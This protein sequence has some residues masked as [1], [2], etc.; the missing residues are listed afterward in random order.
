M[1][2]RWKILSLECAHLFCRWE[3]KKNTYPTLY[4]TAKA[5]LSIPATSVPSERVF[6]LAGFIVR[7]R[8]ARLTSGNVNTLI[9]L[10]KN[11]GNI[12]KDFNYSCEKVEDCNDPNDPDDP[13]GID[14]E[15]HY[16]LID[17]YD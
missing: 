15:N 11:F 16:D 3:S 1:P 5:L 14:T 7:K 9:F 13:Q 17:L 10:N 12:P 2:S 8:R 6:S 4:K